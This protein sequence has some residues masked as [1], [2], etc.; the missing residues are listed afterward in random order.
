[1]PNKNNRPMGFQTVGAGLQINP[2]YLARAKQAKPTAAASEVDDQ[3][4]F[5][6]ERADATRAYVAAWVRRNYGEIN[7]DAI[8]NAL[9]DR[10]PFEV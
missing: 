4:T 6:P 1:M 2:G 7:P 9:S 5:T 10:E 8:E 3:P